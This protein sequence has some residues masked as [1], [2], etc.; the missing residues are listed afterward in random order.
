M[1]TIDISVV[2]PVY[3][4]EDYLY[5][6]VSS[7]LDQTLK[8]IEL[9]C[10]DD[11][12][13]DSSLMILQ[14]FAERDKR[15]RIFHQDNA[16]PGSARN[17]GLQEARGE[18]VIFLDADDW[19][20]SDMLATMLQ[21]TKAYNAEICICRAERFDNV[22]GK[23]LPSAWMLKED[24]LPGDIFSPEEISGHFFQFTYGMV[25]DKLYL[26][27]FLQRTGSHFPELRCA[28]DTAFAF[29]TLLDANRIA[30]LPEVKL[31][32]RVNRNTSVSNSFF[33]EPEAPYYSFQIIYKHIKNSGKYDLFEKSFLNWAMEYLIWNMSNM[34]NRNIRRSYYQMLHQKWFPLLHFEKHAVS[35]YESHSSYIRYCLA[36][37]LPFS[38]YSAI[39]DLY[40][41]FKKLYP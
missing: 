17:R 38:L 12:S 34:S 18:Y 27:S 5:C 7:I 29:C 6:S 31:H 39:L 19:F 40:K 20:E 26:R 15:L 10:V 16:G 30:V 9:I 2:M 25:W 35:F 4:A 36:R 14:G 3:N 13:S 33:Q 32:Y 28:E 24:L 37:Y 11:G 41:A 1:Q 8:E 22:S 23:S 21:K